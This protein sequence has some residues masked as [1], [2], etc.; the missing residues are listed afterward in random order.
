MIPSPGTKL[1]P[2]EIIGPLGKGGM[3]EV[4]RAKDKRLERDVAIKI[5][6]ER[7]SENS[8]ALKRFERE[9]KT[10]A[11]LSHPNILA[12]Y[13]VGLHEGHAF[14]VMELLEGETLRERIIHSPPSWETAIQIITAVIQGL[15]AAHAHGIIH[16]DLKPENI[17]ITRDDRVK[18][19][20]FGL[21]KRFDSSDQQVGTDVET[22]SRATE[23]GT[24]LGTVPYMSPEQA[25]GESLDPKSDIFSTGIILYELLTN[26]LP[27]EGT[28]SAAVIYKILNENPPLVS[29]IRDGIPQWIDP[30][31]E[32]AL[33][34]NKEN[35]YSS[36]VEMLNDL[37]QKGTQAVSWKRHNIL[38]RIRIAIP[39]IGT[40]LIV[41]LAG[42]WFFERQSKI[43]WAKE[44]ALPEIRRMIGE[45]DAWRN[46]TDVYSL[47]EKAEAYIPKDPKLA[48]LFKKCSLNVNI[49]TE[50][51]G[52]RIYMKDYKSPESEWQYLGE[53]PITKR[54]LPIGVFRWKME[55][56]GYETVLAASSTW[57]GS[58]TKADIVFP[59]DII[60]KLDK[61]GS[62]PPDMV[63]VSGAD[64][65]LGKLNDF[66]IDRYEVTNGE[67]KKFIKN[68]GYENPKY[69]KEKFLK[70]GKE[71]TWNEAISQFVD[72]TAQPG[73]A[74]WQAEDYPDGQDDFP[75]SGL[76]WYEAAA[77]CEFAA[78]QL[79]TEQHWG[80][81]RGE[82]TPMIMIPQL[83]G[84]AL[85][86]P[87]SNFR[88]KGPM[89][90]GSLPGITAYGAFDMAGNVREWCWNETPKGRL[91][92]GGAWDDNTYKF[93]DPAQAP[94]MD[95]SSQN[96]FRCAVYPDAPKIPTAAFQPS[97]LNNEW[98][99]FYKEKP[100]PDS[101]FQVYKE[102]FAYDKI[103]LQPRIESRKETSD[104]WIQEKVSFSAA[105]GGERVTAY[106]FLPKNVTPPY[107]T[108]IYY[109]GGASFSQRSS[110]DLENYY[111]FPMF[112]S[113][114]VKNGR[115]VLY[116]LYKGTFER[117]NDSTLSI[118]TGD[119]STHQYFELLMQQVKDLRRSIDYLETRRDI[120]TNKLAYYGMSTGAFWG[121]IITAV[122]DRFKASLLIAGGLIPV[123]R[124]E[125]EPINYVSRV[126]V[127]TLMLNGKYDTILVAE[128]SA[129]PMFDLLG[130]PAKDKLQ[131]FYETDHIPPRNEYIKEILAWLDH[132]LGPVSRSNR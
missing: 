87:F 77:Y 107:Q 123:G 117:G 85:F 102:L 88:N 111:E 112:L 53:S 11:A 125:G 13:D 40:V 101:I 3:G 103:D 17:F 47:A 130:T 92:R 57:N 1:G 108:V 64:T 94:P 54:R 121:C 15:T 98:P 39:V 67:Y 16:R 99:D 70:D 33:A 22:Q 90:V 93:S 35:R 62:I 96:G 8:T 37:T 72:Q 84:F 68:A 46:L 5:L 12:I 32:H 41:A 78:K 48:E 127:P 106:L 55:K 74:T 59:Y 119:L 71:L 44:V 122:E 116:P 50:P 26:H 113:F 60:R 65:S 27:F 19:L 14:V 76:S 2:Y 4:Y 18:I 81:A 20:D 63:R 56:E 91:I 73:P 24:I 124:P 86:A 9:A 110:E 42:Y 45:N 89:A 115:A 128:K 82:S 25:R 66:Y 10:L 83:G 100:V 36:T 43:R 58:E 51:P 61:K 49:K 29:K 23:E 104:E 38:H 129:K 132:Y 79:P 109:P 31:V 52:A 75:V 6:P 30:V 131:K 97:L 34:K 114:I 105:Y 28:N 69:W 7:L 126:K 80:L 118:F 120:D 21:A 95:R